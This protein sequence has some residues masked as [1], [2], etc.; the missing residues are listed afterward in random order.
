MISRVLTEAKLPVKMW[1]KTIESGALE[2]VL[3]LANLPFTYKHVALMPDAHQ[4]YG[5]PIGGVL[6][7]RDV[8]IP[9]AVGVDIGC[10]ML[11]IKTGLQQVTH[12][13]LESWVSLVRHR[14]PLGHKHHKQ[15]Q[16][17]DMMPPWEEFL[18]VVQTEFENA[19]TQLGTLGGG[20]HFIEL[21]KGSDHQVYFMVHSGSRNLGKQVADFYNQKARELNE[22]WHTK[23]PREYNLA[24]LPIEN[25]VAQAYIQEMN[26]CIAFA[27]ANRAMLIAQAVSCLE[28][29][30]NQPIE[31]L[32]TYSSTHNFARRER[33]DNIDVFVHRKGATSAYK[34][35]WVVIPGSQ[36]ARSFIGKGLG[37]RE[38]FY[39]CSHG[40]G[41]RMGRKQAQRTLDLAHEQRHMDNLG[42]VHTINSVKALDEAP[43]A[44]KDI[45]EVMQLQA[46]LVKAEVALTPMA[47]VKG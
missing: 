14:I 9:N 21:Q 11:A 19:R 20:N 4:G 1:L 44:Y 16:P 43:G 29:V 33:V 13:Q 45:E 26:Y 35:E 10:G 36:G 38:S 34:D 8:I 47:V 15:E 37:N 31:Q 27:E 40:A 42:I 5:M 7:T 22:R 12:K 28:E 23:V 18:P 46:D 30:L 41:R 2:Q 17:V 3:N 39:S 24:F 32:A 25:D 6:A